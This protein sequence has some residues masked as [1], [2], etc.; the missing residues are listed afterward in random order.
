MNFGAMISRLIRAARLDASLYE[1]VEADSSLNQEALM[2]VVLVAA[3]TG[4]VGFLATLI[5]GAGIVAALISLVWGVAWAIVGYF[6]FAFLAYF[7]ASKLFGASTD[8]GEMRRVLGYAYGPNILSLIPCLG[9]IVA[10]LWTLVAGVVAV[11]QAMDQD[12]GKA[13]ITTL[14]AIVV[15]VVLGLALGTV[16]SIGNAGFGAITEAFQ[17]I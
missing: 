17:G 8:F 4:I 7:I 13:V 15:V 1:E 3:I 10:P 9:W 14:I 6:L 11:R 16:F 5:T 2:A 12:T